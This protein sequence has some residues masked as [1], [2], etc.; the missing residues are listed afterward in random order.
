MAAD[1][2]RAIEVPDMVGE[3]K[4]VERGPILAPE[5]QAW[6]RVTTVYAGAVILENGKLYL[7]DFQPEVGQVVLAHVPGDD[8]GFVTVR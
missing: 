6:L 3:W 4:V 1:F 8:Y 7:C 2:G 5:L